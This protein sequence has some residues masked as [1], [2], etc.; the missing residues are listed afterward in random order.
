MR[1]DCGGEAGGWGRAGMPAVGVLSRETREGNHAKH[2]G[3]GGPTLSASGRPLPPFGHLPPQAGEGTDC[4]HGA[5]CWLPG[6]FTAAP[7]AKFFG[8]A[9]EEAA[10]AADVAEA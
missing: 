7:S 4:G 8:E 9:D 1:A 5:P 6:A 2:G 3:E 10:G